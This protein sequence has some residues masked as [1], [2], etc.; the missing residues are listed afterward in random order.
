ML[1]RKKVKKKTAV[2]KIETK[3]LKAP[4]QPSK[5]ILLIAAIKTKI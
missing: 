2:I 5:L 3:E 1:K 4:F